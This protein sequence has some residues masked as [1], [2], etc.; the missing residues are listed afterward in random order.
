MQMNEI[1]N[2]G[3]TTW[4]ICKLQKNCLD[5][6]KNSLFAK[7]IFANDIDFLVSAKRAKFFKKV[8]CRVSIVHT[9][10]MTQK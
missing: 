9:I 6:A 3:R 2:Y 5:L 4:L 8:G 7:I 1:L 10:F